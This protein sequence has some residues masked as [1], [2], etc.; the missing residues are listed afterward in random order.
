[1][2]RHSHFC[3]SIIGRLIPKTSDRAELF[4]R[5]FALNSM[6]VPLNLESCRVDVARHNRLENQAMF[7]D[8]QAIR[9][10]P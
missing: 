4:W 5:D 2:T 1:M 8:V 3:R 6:N 10:G 7:H 9:A